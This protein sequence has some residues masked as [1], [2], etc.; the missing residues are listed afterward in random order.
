MSDELLSHE[1]L[2]QGLPARRART[3][4]FLIE[5]RTAQLATRSRQAMER[6]L[7]ERAVQ[8]RELAFFEAFAAGREPPLRPTVQDIERFSPQWAD[9]VPE[10]PRLR[11]AFAHALGEKYRLAYRAVPGIR[12]AV[13]LDTDAVAR[14]Y[15]RQY[16]SPLDSIYAPRISVPARIRWRFSR[17]GA[18]L[19]SLPPFWTAFSLTITETVGSAVLALPIAVARLGPVPGIVLLVVFGLVN[20]ATVAAISEAFVRNGSVRYS[21]AFVG[22]IVA[23][24]LGPFASAVASVALIVIT[25]LTL[26]ADYVGVSTTLAQTVH[27]SVLLGAAVVFA[28]GML[29]LT[30]KTLNATVSS[31]LVV[32]FVTITLILIMASLSATHLRWAYVSHSYVPFIHGATFDRALV[33]SIFG[34][35][36][37]AYFGHLSAGNCARV[38]LQRDPGGRSLFWG[39]VAAQGG[40]MVIYCLWVLC[41]NGAIAP[42]VL[43]RQDGTALGPLAHVVGPAVVV[44]GTIYVFLAMGMAS[45]HYLRALRNL[46]LERLPSRP[47]AVQGGGAK[48]RF[49]LLSGGARTRSLVGLC[50]LVAVFVIVEWL[51]LLGRVS[52]TGPINLAGVV[53]VSVFAGIFPALLIASARR[54]GEY[55]PAFMFRS[56]GWPPVVVGLYVL[57][58]GN[59]LLHGLIIW[60][61]PVERAVALLMAA[62]VLAA[63]VFT[64]RG[65]AF[66]R[67]VTVELRQNANQP[68]TNFS[69]VAAGRP[70]DVSAQLDG[71]DA[72]RDIRPGATLP[73]LDNVERILVSLPPA[74][75]RQLEV[76][77]HRITATGDSEALG[78]AVRVRTDSA[79]EPSVTRS[80]SMVRLPLPPTACSVEILMGDATPGGT[81]TID[82]RSTRRV[83]GNPHGLQLGRSSGEVDPTYWP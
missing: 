55:V 8:E 3:L 5:S 20:M 4:L 44:L 61:S 74:V 78:V 18:A 12:A 38:V 75:A 80:A 66:W 25:T 60:Q 6:F 31:A 69:V 10:S 79:A 42:A 27:V 52:F 15:Q 68:G 41:V 76:W 36:L 37:A 24:Y 28:G 49:G 7:T 46:V 81:R 29:L 73:P 48:A 34:V 43:A 83:P 53:A 54:K 22:R 70:L 11:A 30:R 62:L 13:G 56:L 59:I 47:A 77:V 58:I 23:D 21:D 65:G 14:S 82:L 67:S 1:E 64:V 17:F 45:V 2:Q 32:G 26:V 35:L 72:P 19:E 33:A 50:P 39:C 71:S 40:A 9:L 51:L 63:T 57:F 16:G